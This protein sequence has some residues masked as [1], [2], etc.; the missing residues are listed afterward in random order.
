M[1]NSYEDLEVWQLAVT[2]VTEI[3]SATRQFPRDELYALTS[4]LRRA[5]ISVP[6]NIAEGQGRLSPKEFRQFLGHARGSLM[7]IETQLVIAANLGYLDRERLGRLSGMCK[8]VSQMLYRL[9]QAIS[10]TPLP[11]QC[12]HDAET[13]N[14]KP[15][16]ANVERGTRN[17]ER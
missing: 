15:P 3:Y 5:A 2:L 1:G 10:D 12:Q 7:E 9:L 16:A 13:K 14:E 4:Q 11:A 8:R 6:S 17:V